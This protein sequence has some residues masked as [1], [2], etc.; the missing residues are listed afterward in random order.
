MFDVFVKTNRLLGCPDTEDRE[1][2]S[3]ERKAQN[4]IN[5]PK[6]SKFA[7]AVIQTLLD[8]EVNIFEQV[9]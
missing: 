5:R 3:E 9:W 8:D 6:N 4:A 7:L 2:N 1:D